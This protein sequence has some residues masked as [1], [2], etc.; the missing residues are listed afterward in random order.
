MFPSSRPLP[1]LKSLAMLKFR[2]SAR[3]A[4]IDGVKR[5]VDIL[6]SV[7][8]SG[9]SETKFVS[10]CNFALWR[11]VWWLIVVMNLVIK[12]DLRSASA[13]DDADPYAQ[14]GGGCRGGG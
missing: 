10:N 4:D 3:T 14:S 7:R 6:P 13:N 11:L 8:T 5:H 9:R 12:L 1:F 2:F